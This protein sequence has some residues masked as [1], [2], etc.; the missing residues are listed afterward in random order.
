MN[1]LRLLLLGPPG[2]GKGTQTSKLLA[3]FPQLKTVSSGDILRQHIRNGTRIGSL[4]AQFIKQGRLVPDELITKLVFKHLSTLN[5][6]W[7]LDGFPRTLIQAQNLSQYLNPLGKDINLVIELDV[8]ESVILSRIEER[9][10][11]L[12]SGRTY[13]D[14]YNAPKVPGIDDITGEPLVR[15]SDDNKLAMQT[16]IREYK[17]TIAPL[18]QYY[19][20]KGL[21]TAISGDSSDEIYP[22]LLDTVLEVSRA[23]EETAI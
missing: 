14:T 15:R 4:A 2:A 3:E 6:G 5:N 17:A 21:L 12:Q 18:R 13:N 1:Q 10:V 19:K 7:I 16:R 20:S 22:I 11:H 8:P 9:W 23:Q